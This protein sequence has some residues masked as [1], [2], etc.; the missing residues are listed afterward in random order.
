MDLEKF[1]KL[2]EEELDDIPKG[3]LQANTNYRDVEGFSSMHALIIIA[4][5]DNEFDV[6]LKGN[7][8]K[9]TNTIEELYNLVQSKLN[10]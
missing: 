5:I 2:L 6:L 4:C 10:A 9:E 1:I 8:L 7:E 3:N